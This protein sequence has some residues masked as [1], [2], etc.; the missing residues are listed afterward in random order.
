I[1]SV[2]LFSSAAILAGCDP[3][4]EDDITVSKGSL[5]F[6]KYVAVGNSLTA[7]Y[8]D[9]GLNLEGQ[10]LSYPNLL[11]NQ[12]LAVGGGD[13]VQPLFTNEQYNGSG[14]IRLAGFT[15]SG[16]P[17]L[18][19]VTTNLAVRTDVQPLPGGPR[20]T[21]FAD[22][23]KIQNW[24]VPGMSVLSASQAVYGGI[25]PYFDRLLPD[26]EVGKKSYIEKVAATQPTFF[27]VW[28][29]NNDVLTYATS[30]GVSD[31]N[32]P[33]SG[34]TPTATFKTIYSQLIGALTQGGAEG[35]VANIPDVTSVPF[36]TTV[37]LQSVRLAAKN[38]D[39]V[40]YIRYGEG[41]NEVRPIEAGDYILLTTQAAIGRP[42]NV[43][44][45]QPIPH[46]FHPANP[47]TDREVLDKDEV[48]EIKTRTTE[49]NQAIS[50]IASANKLPVFD[51]YTFF[52]Q[53]K[54][55][56]VLNGVGYSSLYIVGNLFSL[57]GVHLTPRGYAIVANEFINTINSHYKTSVPTLDVT[58][59]RTVLIP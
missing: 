56:F 45:P 48:A 15:S 43:G 31:P 25:N 13:F 49:L 2:L 9:N 8:Q 37:T 59:F 35:V 19:P 39:L 55:G 3:E 34:L 17:M 30:G 29:G 10:V 44:G 7:G 6:T 46:G 28:L 14:Y 40:L 42:D 36:F 50:E 23:A 52:N 5:D 54:N 16:S 33:F 18:Q 4:F 57:D 58:Q 12:F 20:L 32:N 27:S 11:A 26:A 51:A 47:L 24:G 53:R 1:G 21:K 41:Q 22:P 38:N